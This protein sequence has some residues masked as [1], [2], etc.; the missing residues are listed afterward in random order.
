MIPP[1]D[2][3]A[4]IVVDMQR[5]FLEQD[6]AMGRLGFDLDPL[7]AVIE[8]CRRLVVAARAA[9]VPIVWTRYVYAEGHVDGGVMVELLPGLKTENALLAGSDEIEVEPAL[10][11]LPE[12]HVVD[13]NRPS[14]FWGTDLDA[15]I[16]ANGIENLIV[17]GITTN[18][19][20]ESTVRDAS[21]RDIPTYVVSDAVAETSASRHDHALLAMS[22]LFARLVTVADV[23]TAL[24]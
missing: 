16:K 10:G 22:M 24:A 23:E 8:P 15:W 5:G 13:K 9:G 18:C 17:C 3:A 6:S 11:P 21:H 14:A 2:K 20:V 12:D 7:I 19:C 4:L 1:R